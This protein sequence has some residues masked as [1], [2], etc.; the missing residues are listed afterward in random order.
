MSFAYARAKL[1]AD[2]LVGLL[3]PDCSRIEIA[4]SVRRERPLVKDVELVC[5]PSNLNSFALKLYNGYGVA[6]KRKARYIQF[7]IGVMKCDLFLPQPHDYFRQF[8]IRT[9]S[10]DYSHKVIANAWVKAGWVGTEDGLRR[11]VECEKHT[12]RWI[13]KST[14]SNVTLPPVWQSEEDFFHW[15]GLAYLPPMNREV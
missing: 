8:A 13:C 6:T 15:L 9:G 1:I 4:G 3:K 10:A 7:N 5:I 11:A 2:E 14:G 12:N